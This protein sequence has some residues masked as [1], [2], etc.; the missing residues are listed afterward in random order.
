MMYPLILS[1]LLMLAVII[2]RVI[3]LKK[4]K[5][6]IPEIINIV[7]QL[8]SLKDID[9]AQNIC[10]RYKGPLPNLIKIAL[11]HSEQKAPSEIKELIEEQG[12]QEIR[13]LE[14]RLIVLE[15]IAVIA[16]LMG[17]LGT[18]L[19]MI[20]VFNVIKEQ[21]IGQASALAGGIYEALFTTVTG[22]FI[23]IPA[24]IFFNYFSHKAEDFVLDIEKNCNS[25]IHKLGIIKSNK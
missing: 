1:S 21:G 2:E 25:L 12:R 8:K 9:L 22:L 24:L 16:P 3:S 4:N 11:T 10:S 5:I 19:G 18:V 6:I 15:T 17:L 14:K 7:E 13:Y 23:A 20:R